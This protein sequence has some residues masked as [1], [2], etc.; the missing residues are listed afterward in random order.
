MTSSG[1]TRPV[2]DLGRVV[3]PKEIRNRYGWEPHDIIEIHTGDNGTVILKKQ[4]D[5]CALCG[6][7]TGLELH[8]KSGKLVCLSCRESMGK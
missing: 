3:V 2:D 8:E 7:L 6:S 1:M 4:E 5:D